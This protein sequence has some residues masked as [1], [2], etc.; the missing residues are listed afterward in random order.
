MMTLLPAKHL[1]ELLS[2]IEVPG[3][4]IEYITLCVDGKINIDRY[5]GNDTCM[6]RGEREGEEKRERE[7]EREREY[8]AVITTMH[9]AYH[10]AAF[11]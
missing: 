1:S 4:E 8:Y 3:T 5:S 6:Y 7:R 9:Y 2:D 10:R 11:Q